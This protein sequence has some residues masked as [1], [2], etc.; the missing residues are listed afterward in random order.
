MQCNACQDSP[1]ILLNAYFSVETSIRTCVR[2][3]EFRNPGIGSQI[4]GDRDQD[5]KALEFRNTSAELVKKT[6]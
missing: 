2:T 6:Y 4:C 3:F 5:L 1:H